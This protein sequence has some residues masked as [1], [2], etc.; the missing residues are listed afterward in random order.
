MWLGHCLI[1][2][3]KKIALA[4]RCKADLERVGAVQL[5]HEMYEPLP[6]FHENVAVPFVRGSNGVIPALIL[7]H[8]AGGLSNF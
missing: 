5:R 3:A 1:D 7:M 6:F 2:G 8:P 4:T